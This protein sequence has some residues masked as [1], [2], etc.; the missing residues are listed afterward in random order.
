MNR[1]ILYLLKL[2]MFNLVLIFASTTM[3]LSAETKTI[4]IAG[5]E[6]TIDPATYDYLRVAVATAENENA[7]LLIV[8]LN[9]PGGLLSSV[10]SMA[11]SVDQSKV[12]VVVYVTPGGASATSAGALL[13]LA[14]HVAVMAPGTNI[15]AAHPVG[16]EGKDIEGSMGE[17]A[18][19]DTAAFARSLAELRGRDPAIAQ[20]V[21]S[22]SKSFT[23]NEALEKKLID[24]IAKDRDELLLKLNGL[25]IKFQG[26]EQVIDSLGSEV[27][28]I[29]MTWG[30]KLLH[31]LANPNVAAIL[32]TIAMLLI[33][34]E[35]S[36]PG[37]SVAGV[38]GAICLLVAFIAFQIIPVQ[39][40]G[41]VL[42]LLGMAMMVAEPF[43]STHG[44][45]AGGGGAFICARPSLACGSFQIQHACEPEYLDGCCAWAGWWNC[46]YCI[47]SCKNP[48]AYKKSFSQH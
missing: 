37:I 29:V 20:D 3:V 22:K 10:R 15:G 38:L 35:V 25:K 31:Y 9:T 27:K 43:V 23:A 44:I 7:K 19:N 18:V 46:S 26:K 16:P 45:L 42:L 30:Q 24:F 4:V 39:T 8:E 21:V 40:G 12:P 5:I 48:H 13:M 41:V 32:M 33:Y 14:S 36:H 28:P 1:L 34:V 2:L 17:K 47:L 11:Q 6:G